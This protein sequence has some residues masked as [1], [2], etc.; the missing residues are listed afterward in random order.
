MG[1]WGKIKAESGI[2]NL[3]K[4]G[5]AAERSFSHFPPLVFPYRFLVFYGF[6]VY[7]TGRNL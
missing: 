4:F 2:A 6:L 7:V 3:F 1:K 5:S